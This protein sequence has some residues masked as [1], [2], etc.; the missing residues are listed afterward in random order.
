M[1][2]VDIY[3][4]DEITEGNFIEL[5]FRNLPSRTILIRTRNIF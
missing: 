5:Y 3:G 4:E 2:G 1:F